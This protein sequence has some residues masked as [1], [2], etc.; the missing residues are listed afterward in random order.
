MEE[1][2][3]VPIEQVGEEIHERS[4]GQRG[5]IMG[6]ALSTS[7]LAVL[8]AIASLLAGHYANEG[9]LEQLEA[10][11]QWSFYQSK[12]VKE[13][14]LHTKGD[15]LEALGKVAPEKDLEKLSDYRREQE[16]IRL[17]AGRLAKESKHHMRLHARLARSVTLFQI[18]IGVSAI[19][20]LTRRKRFWLLGLGFGM[21]GFVLLVTA[22][23]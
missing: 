17:E 6:V 22:F 20:V 13:N 18:A 1:A 10:S 7:L 21:G 9:V 19:A 12:S 4:H 14:L 5:W 2:P 23:F 16:E 8:A 15:I 11:N 3:E